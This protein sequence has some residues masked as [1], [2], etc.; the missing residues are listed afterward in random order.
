MGAALP[1]SLAPA[2]A[3][4]DEALTAPQWVELLGITPQA[5]RRR[6]TEF[7]RDVV[8][9]G[10]RQVVRQLFSFGSLPPDYRQQLTTLREKH[11]APNFTELLSMRSVE[12]RKWEPVK[13]WLDYKPTVRKR[14]E[15]RH[16]MM[17]VWY[18]ALNAGRPKIEANRL[19]RHAFEN[20]TAKS[21]S[22]KQV[23]R[24][25]K[26]ID[27]R[28][29][30]FAPLEAYC[31]DKECPHI[32]AR[33]HVP[34]EFL[35][36]VKSK[37][38]E[39]GVR[40]WSAAIRFFELEWQNG[41]PVPGLG[42]PE[43]GQAFPY[44]A[45]QLRKFAPSK[46]A[47]EQ[48]GRGKFRAKVAGLLPALPLA[49]QA[50]R[51]R[52]RIV[53]DDKRLDLTGKDDLTGRP[54]E[55]TLY[56]AMDEGTR[57]I[58][59]YLLR[60]AGAVRQTDVEALTAFILRVCGMAGKSAGYATT[61]KFERGTVAISPARERLL[62]MLYPGQLEISRTTMVGG[63]NTPGDF[64]QSA[65]GNFFGKGK[66]ESFMATLD[67]Y[68]AHLAGQRGN[69][70]RNQPLMLGDLLATPE[71]LASPQY[72]LKGS[73][74][75]EAVLAAQTA[76]AVHWERTGT[77]PGAYEAS[78]ATG[79]EG[80]LLFV[81]EVHAAVQ[82]V[83]AYY[84][85]ER[86]HRREGFLD[87]P[88]VQASGALHYV[89]ESSNDKA[90]R[91]ERELAA[92]G[93]TLCR[94]SEADAATLLHKC[95]PVTVRPS[96]A[97]VRINGVE[98]LYWHESSLAIDAAQQSTLGEKTYLALYNPEDPRELYLLHNPPGH[99]PPSADALPAGVEPHFFEA[100]PYYAPAESN[101]EA[102]KA[103]QAARVASNHSKIS[104]EITRN[105]VPFLAANTERRERNTELAEPLRAAVS[106][107]RDAEAHRE[108]LPPT[109]LSTELQSTRNGEQSR[110]AQQADAAPAYAAGLQF[111]AAQDNE[112]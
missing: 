66:L 17:E 54:V 11:V 89:R 27:E 81:S 77:L 111:E 42:R 68:T 3:F 87:L 60:E 37:A 49:S 86:G 23:Y 71:Q 16:A 29:G 48:A 94:I 52:E 74:I 102:A 4:H 78:R 44:S 40:L 33:L 25:A 62:K 110:A 39:P 50:L 80:P 26:L 90:T 28:G 101:D 99:F 10:S 7:R 47:R 75:E 5:F 57:Q 96:G 21:I 103:R 69:V 32:G 79:S 1:V 34:E 63:H 105:I 59:G 43:R 2:L 24:I 58:L 95:K 12:I 53:F 83:I 22:D 112:F 106:V 14:A 19:A 46:A 76:Q 35:A 31:D 88:M 84:N 82:A 100:L 72:K 51:L 30:E 107:L 97:R 92:Q 98:R 6:C 61:L 104:H 109:S 91:L 65:S 18:T 67:R 73:M 38:M 108:E 93:R 85:A 70:Y 15:D 9:V 64:A 36:A 55:L 13:D 20:R 45:D 56:I 41:R 8:T